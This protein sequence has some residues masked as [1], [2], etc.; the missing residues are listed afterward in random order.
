[1]KSVFL[2]FAMFSRIPMPMVEWN[3]KNRRFILAA[4]PMVGA[5]VGLGLWLWQMLCARM[6]FSPLLWGVLCA[7]MP[8]FVTGGIHMDGFADTIDALA[9]HADPQRKRQIL[10]DPNSGAFAVIAVGCYLLLHAALLC[11]LPCTLH[12]VLSLTLI[13]LLSRTGSGLVSL[14]FPGAGGKGLL[15][16]FR[17]SA[18]SRLCGGILG[19][20]LLLLSAGC[21]CLLGWAGLLLPAALLLT[22]LWLYRIATRE[23]GGMSGDLSGYFLQ[24]AEM[25]MVILLVLME[26]GLFA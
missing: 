12:T 24:L 26:R 6:G 16:A 7:L 17:E 18:A 23:F 21:V 22:A 15:S 4:F 13:H 9:S 3:E 2:A 25:A 10:K 14:F 1:M 8:L 20:W 19:A 11:E 5:A